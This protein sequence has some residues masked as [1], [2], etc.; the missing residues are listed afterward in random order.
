MSESMP[1]VRTAH[2]D[3]MAERPGVY[4]RWPAELI[5]R[6]GGHLRIASSMAIERRLAEIGITWSQA[7]DDAL[8][9]S[10]RGV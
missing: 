3:G 1:D 4:C 5:R 2:A 7:V 8:A 6:E 10:D 9:E